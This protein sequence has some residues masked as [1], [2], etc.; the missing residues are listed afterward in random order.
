LTDS[1]IEIVLLLVAH[2]VIDSMD[3]R[4]NDR[5]P[6]DHKSAPVKEAG[7]HDI[8]FLKEKFKILF[9]ERNLSTTKQ[10]GEQVFY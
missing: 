8:Y 6:T 7:V 5:H 10:A 3:D 9:L 2:H 1:Q 4:G